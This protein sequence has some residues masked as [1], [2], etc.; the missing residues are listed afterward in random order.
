MES[1]DLAI[2]DCAG[3]SRSTTFLSYKPNTNTTSRGCSMRHT[4]CCVQENSH[5]E[6]FFLAGP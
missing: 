5:T 3:N 2:K 4:E 1:L 6:L